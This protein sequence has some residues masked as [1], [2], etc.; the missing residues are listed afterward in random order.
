M[1]LRDFRCLIWREIF[2]WKQE[3]RQSR[4]PFAHFQIPEP[5]LTDI[6]EGGDLFRWYATCDARDLWDI[7]VVPN[8]FCDKNTS[9]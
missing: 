2:D 1:H 4:P 3:A 7:E 9:A 5:L 6:G 8:L